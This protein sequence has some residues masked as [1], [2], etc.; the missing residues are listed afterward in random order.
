MI[1]FIGQCVPTQNV[2]IELKFSF[3]GV[4]FTNILLA[5][6]RQYSCANKK[7]YLNC[8]HRKALR[9]TFVPKWRA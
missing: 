4:N 6:L 2:S 9:K 1:N 3:S 8:K 5:Q 7:F